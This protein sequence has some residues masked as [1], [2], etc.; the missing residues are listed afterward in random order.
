MPDQ[1]RYLQ[2][3]GHSDQQHPGSP[4]HAPG[5]QRAPKIGRA[6]TRRKGHGAS[7][8]SERGFRHLR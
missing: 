3:I 7:K 5:W 1:A 8:G 4:T 2:A 6:G